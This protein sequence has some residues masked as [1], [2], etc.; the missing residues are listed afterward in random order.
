MIDMVHQI[1]DHAARE[2]N[3]F[4]I[5]VWYG[6][7]VDTERNWPGANRQQGDTDLDIER[8]RY[9]FDRRSP[10]GPVAVLPATWLGVGVTLIRPY[11]LLEKVAR[12]VTSKLRQT[13]F[14]RPADLTDAERD[15]AKI[16]EEGKLEAL[17]YWRQIIGPDE[18]IS[19]GQVA[20]LRETIEQLLQSGEKV[21]LADLPIPNWHRNASVYASSYARSIQSLFDHFAGQRG[22]T[23]LRMDDLADDGN[24][25]DEVHVRPRIARIWAM[26]LARVLNDLICPASFKA[27][28]PHVQ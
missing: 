13:L 27:A 28:S 19:Q 6:M 17:A 9:G 5:G 23:S 24:F 10:T 4:V 8:Y 22:F 3:T 1:Q 2:N 18:E 7:F 20:V 15:T 11:L 14:A 16:S 12:D 21:V 26:R 25:S